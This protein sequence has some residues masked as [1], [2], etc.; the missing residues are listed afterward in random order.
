MEAGRT[1]FSGFADDSDNAGLSIVAP[2]PSRDEIDL[3]KLAR[4]TP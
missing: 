1:V 4:I 2:R 3:E